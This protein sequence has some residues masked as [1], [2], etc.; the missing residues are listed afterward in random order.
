MC[1]YMVLDAIRAEWES[2]P[3]R[4]AIVCEDLPLM[5]RAPGSQQFHLLGGVQLDGAVLW[6]VDEL[7]G[8]SFVLGM[9]AFGKVV[10]L[11]QFK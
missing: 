3:N 9:V 5:G 8:G 10:S 1:I 2:A 7:G 4:C 6:R 11:H